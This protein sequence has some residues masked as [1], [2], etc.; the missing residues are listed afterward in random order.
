MRL[1]WKE[2]NRND[3]IYSIFFPI[4]VI[5]LIVGLSKLTSLVGDGFG[6]D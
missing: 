2:W 1:N 3:I 4:K 6:K 5:L